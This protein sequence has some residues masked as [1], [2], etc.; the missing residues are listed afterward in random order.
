MLDRSRPD[1]CAI[2][3]FALGIASW[4]A[5]AAGV[6][7]AAAWDDAIYPDLKGA[8]RRPGAA[9]WDPTKPS[10]LRQEAPLTAE[11]QAILE[12]NLADIAAGG[13]AHNP[14]AR[15]R[16]AACAR[17]D[18]LRS[19]RIHHAGHHLYAKRPPDREPPITDGRG[20]PDAIKRRSTALDRPGSTRRRRPHDPGVE[21]RH[22]G[23]RTLMPTALH[24]TDNA[25]VVRADFPRWPIPTST[26][27]S[28]VRP[29]ADALDLTR[30]YR[31]ERNGLI[32][33]PCA[34]T[35]RYLILGGET[36]FRV[37]SHPDTTR[38]PA[39]PDLKF[40]EPSAK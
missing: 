37:G 20:W 33:E 28:H 29:C 12:A 17:D 9:Q 19:A 5:L 7:A 10:G 16:Q 23:P 21:P 11:Y 38:G 4:V 1:R 15:C 3:L 27:R 26:T 34:E 22:E 6:G 14:Q 39:P 35:N 18:R 2:R 13:Q 32:G 31:R 8:W 25:T 30:S 24:H 40:F 36:Y